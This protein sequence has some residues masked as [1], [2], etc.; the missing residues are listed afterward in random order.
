M[1]TSALVRFPRPA[2]DAIR[3]DRLEQYDLFGTPPEIEY[4]Q[5]TRLAAELM[6]FPISLVSIIGQNEQWLKSRY[7]TDVECTPRGTAFC[8]HTIMSD[9]LLIVPD[10]LDD[11]RFRSNPLVTS[12]P[13]IRF[14]AGAPLMTED[15]T[16]VGALC[17]IDSV[18]RTFNSDDEQLLRRLA[19]IITRRFDQRKETI[20]QRKALDHLA[21]ENVLLVE[22][23]QAE[24]EIRTEIAGVL[25]LIETFAGRLKLLAF[26]ASLEAARAGTAGQGFAVVANEVR[27]LADHTRDATDR[28][29]RLL[30]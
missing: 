16:Q 10:A 5:I 28:A 26:N 23:D 4:D 1:N 21:D 14:Y 22:R 27:S 8:A 25:R 17:L 6:N 24:G 15:G 9:D 18:P 29:K 7:G 13:H 11:P 12:A 30:N 3:L 2:N 19:A 20:L